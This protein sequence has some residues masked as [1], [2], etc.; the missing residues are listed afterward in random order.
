MHAYYETV[1]CELEFLK[2]VY[3]NDIANGFKH[4][5]NNKNVVK[6]EH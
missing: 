2:V 3:A 6:S 5:C 4:N 1:L